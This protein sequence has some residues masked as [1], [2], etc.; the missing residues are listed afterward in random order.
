MPSDRQH[1]RA[2]KLDDQR[3]RAADRG[4]GA[5]DGI[6]RDEDRVA[7]LPAFATAT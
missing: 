2:E 5:A 3:E 1:Q 6:E 4:D 7:A